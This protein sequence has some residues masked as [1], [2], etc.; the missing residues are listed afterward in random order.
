MN[1]ILRLGFLGLFVFSTTISSSHA[2]AVLSAQP[3][4]V[5]ADSDG[6]LIIGR[7]QDYVPSDIDANVLFD[8]LRD[9]MKSRRDFAWDVVEQV[10]QPVEL[11]LLD[12]ATRVEVPLW[13]TW[14]EGRPSN[15]SANLELEELFKLYFKNLKPVLDAD[16]KADI[17]PVIDATLNEFSSKD[18]SSSLTDDNLSSVLHQLTSAADVGERLGQGTTMFSPSFIEHAMKEARGIDEC[19]RDVANANTPPPSNDQFSHCID[20]FPRS[21][22]MIKTAWERLS[23]GVPEHDTGSS[24]MT[25]VIKEGTWPGPG[26]AD[27]NPSIRNPDRTNIY[28]NITEEGAEWALTGIHFVTKDV[29]EW[30]WISLWWDPDSNEDFGADRPN[31]ID[32]LNNGV[33]KNYKMCVNSS[34]AEGDTSP[35]SHYT[36]TQDSLG[37]SIKAVYDAIQDQID[38]GAIDR[39]EDFQHF[40]GQSPPANLPHALGPWSAPFN[41]QTSWCSN[42][43]IESH[44]AN[45]RTSCI[46]C[47]QIAFTINE[48]RATDASFR[49]ALVGDIP[50]FARARAR[51]NFTAEFSWSFGFEFK[52]SIVVGKASTGFEWPTN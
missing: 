41:K 31:S 26:R 10:L 19:R 27:L 18:L 6:R 47:H 37:D 12:G 44:A 4:E 14:Y 43:N 30:V 42:P 2:Q 25:R 49:D 7:G 33:W 34:F 39:P 13:Q 51:Q 23:M 48:D 3:P 9:S 29:R 52:P 15:A 28:T 46:G 1:S 17:Q 50:Q 40:F 35:W 38:N 20:E 24:A 21:A 11:T 45:G 5:L 36:G 16:P 32:S 22:V 8:Q